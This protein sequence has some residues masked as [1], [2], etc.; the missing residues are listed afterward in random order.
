MTLSELKR[1]RAAHLAPLA[2]DERTSAHR[3]VWNALPDLLAA[4]EAAR[5]Y[6]RRERTGGGCDLETT[7]K[8]A[9]AVE[10]AERVL[11]AALARVPA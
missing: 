4:V 10:D 11:D 7:E 6:R 2:L 9:S 8:L 3:D 5:E 1:L